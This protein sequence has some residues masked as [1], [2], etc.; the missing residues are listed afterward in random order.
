[1]DADSAP[2]PP[3]PL[4]SEVIGLPVADLTALD[5]LIPDTEIDGL[6]YGALTLRVASLRGDAARHRAEPRRDAL[7][8]ARFGTGRQ[9]LVLVAMASCVVGSGD[10]HRAAHDA[11]VWMARAVG[12]SYARLAEDVRTGDRWA[13]KSGLHR[14]TDRG[15]GGLRA[16]VAASEANAASATTD[17]RYPSPDGVAC[18][19]MALRCLLLPVDPD[20]RTRVFFGIGAGGLYRLR[21][22]HWQ[23]L[24]P[25]PP[26]P[27][28]P[29]DAPA[30]GGGTARPY[31]TGATRSYRTGTVRPY[32]IDTARS[33]E[34]DTPGPAETGSA[35]SGG[36]GASSGGIGAPPYGTGAARSYETDTPGPDAAGSAQPGGISAPPYGTGTGRPYETDTPGPAEAGSAQPGGFGTSSGGIGA[37]SYGTGTFEPHGAVIPDLTSARHPTEDT[38]PR[39]TEGTAPRTTSDA[40]R[41]PPLADPAPQPDPFLFRASVARP[42]DTLLLCSAGL[43]EP[44]RED[45]VF[46]DRL[47]VRWAAKEPPDFAEF[48]ADVAQKADGHAK[49]RTAAAVWDT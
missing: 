44:L 28:P 5:D 10:A 24:E 37:P 31:G 12:R 15:Y 4:A 45:P 36:I 42:G 20:C 22:G 48:L 21:D 2:P 17:P 7:L 47:A 32:G 11:C 23:D 18:R 30:V 41:R 26:S 1:M 16:R 19:G 6:H 34:T 39:P 13:L 38:D 46:A 35:R 8:T 27:E 29:M 43:A 14:L 33:Y 25:A 40:D 9:A 49:D 3:D